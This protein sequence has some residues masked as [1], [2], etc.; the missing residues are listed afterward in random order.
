MD[1]TRW[2]VGDERQLRVFLD[3]L[4][5]RCEAVENLAEKDGAVL[6]LVVDGTI[7]AEVLFRINRDASRM[8]NP[9]LVKKNALLTFWVRKLKPIRVEGE[10][11]A[12]WQRYANEFV[13]FFC[14]I[15]S[16]NDKRRAVLG[17]RYI[18]NLIYDFR[19]RAWSPY[20]ITQLYETIWGTQND[21]EF[22]LN[23]R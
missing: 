10:S 9:N 12:I 23:F 15:D 20:A 18:S 22:N 2:G 14:G 19:F 17:T 5:L 7:G 21:D 8:H 1:A 11:R 3:Y 16:L 4:S 13:A 6:E